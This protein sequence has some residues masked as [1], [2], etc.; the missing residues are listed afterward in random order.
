MIL[1]HNISCCLTYERGASH[2]D[3]DILCRCAND[4]ADE[5]EGLTPNEEPATTKDVTQTT[6]E[7]HD[8]TLTK[9]LD[10]GHEDNI[11]ARSNIGVDN[12]ENIDLWRA[13]LEAGTDHAKCFVT[14]R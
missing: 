10:D 9:R 11:G 12:R 4:G 5:T 7:K 1:D 13:K 6:N 8:D 3:I 2:E 14:Y